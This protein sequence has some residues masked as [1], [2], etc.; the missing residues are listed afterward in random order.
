MQN[1]QRS[2]VDHPELAASARGRLEQYFASTSTASPPNTQ[3]TKRQ[4]PGSVEAVSEAPSNAQSSDEML[5]EI[6]T[7]VRSMDKRIG[8]LEDGINFATSEIA[9]LR[10]ENTELKAANAALTLK[11]DSMEERFEER[12]E[13]LECAL[14]EES[15]K[16]DALEANSRLIHLEISGIPK[17]EGETWDKCKEHVASVMKL[18]GSENDKTA[19]DVAHRK[20]AGGIIA[21]FKSREQRNEVYLKR[22]NLVGKTS[23][24]LGF[25][26]PTK[27]NDI[28]INES[29]SFDRSKLMKDIRDKLKILNVGKG[30]DDRI[31]AKTQGGVIK[32]QNR[33]GLYL[34]VTSM[35]Q[36][37]TM[38]R[39]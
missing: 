12:L 29:L 19:I 38:Y 2:P 39:I 8:V 20:M 4:R 28:Y 27:G 6:L 25:E 26:L 17:S 7:T 21:R 14:E 36:F 3:A 37:N 10:A 15:Q 35:K 11:I 30:K 9:E 24:D 34:P 23:L 16:R 1:V 32:V 31:K 22:F 18:I 13:N 33:S 5:R